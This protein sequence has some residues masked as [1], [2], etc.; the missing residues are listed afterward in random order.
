[1]RSTRRI[2]NGTG[3]TVIPVSM[4]LSKSGYIFSPVDEI[5]G[6]IVLV[7]KIFVRR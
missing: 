4:T 2:L 7:A 6:S 5:A 1:M 3:P